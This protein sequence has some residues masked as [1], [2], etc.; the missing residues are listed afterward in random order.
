M[1]ILN[2]KPQVEKFISSLPPKHKRQIKDYILSLQ[3]NPIPHDAKKL[4]GYEHYTRVDT[5]EYRII[6]RYESETDL[7]TVVLAD[8]RNDDA[9]YRMAKRILKP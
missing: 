3:I 4:I 7:L 2:I 1:P 8:K 5:G 9:I 6:Y